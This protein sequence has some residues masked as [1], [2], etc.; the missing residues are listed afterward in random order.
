MEMKDTLAIRR[1]SR[2]QDFIKNRIPC[3]RC[4]NFFSPSPRLLILR[5]QA[6]L[7]SNVFQIGGGLTLA[8]AASFADEIIRR[9]G[10]RSSRS[11]NDY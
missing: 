11:N 8:E 9:T 7:K 4:N 3:L 5:M 1:I 6:R 10:S 2:S